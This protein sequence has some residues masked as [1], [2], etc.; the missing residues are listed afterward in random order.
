MKPI[1]LGWLTEGQ[2]IILKTFS[3]FLLAINSRKK[4]KYLLLFAAFGFRISDSCIS[5]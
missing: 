2:L 4:K 5:G 3:L 1:S